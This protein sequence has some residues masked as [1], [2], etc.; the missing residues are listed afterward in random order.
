MLII[1]FLNQIICMLYG[2]I[3]VENKGVIIWVI[4]ITPIFNICKLSGLV[5]SSLHNNQILW[6][7]QCVT[8]YNAM[9]QAGLHS[10]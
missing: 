2:D 6:T 1:V 4:F 7:I 8:Q 3:F 9:E 5:F 10:A